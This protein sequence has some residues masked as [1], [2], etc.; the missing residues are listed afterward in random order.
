MARGGVGAK[1]EMDMQREALILVYVL[2]VC[3]DLVNTNEF[4]GLSRLYDNKSPS[5]QAPS[6]FI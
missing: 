1:A 2:S 3:E 6:R 4:D 5:L